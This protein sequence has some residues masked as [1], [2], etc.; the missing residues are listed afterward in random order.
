M[1]DY[2]EMLL[3]L[4]LSLILLTAKFLAYIMICSIFFNDKNKV[5]Y[6]CHGAVL[7]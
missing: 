4:A 2:L 1:I 5:S 3:P 7:K 6:L